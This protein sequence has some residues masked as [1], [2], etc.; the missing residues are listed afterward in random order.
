MG[1]RVNMRVKTDGGLYRNSAVRPLPSR[2]P[3]RRGSAVLSSVLIPLAPFGLRNRGLSR[4]THYT[5]AAS[6]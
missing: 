6:W 3:G 1:N 5:H 2:E 4:I